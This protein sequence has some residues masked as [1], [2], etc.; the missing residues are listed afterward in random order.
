MNMGDRRPLASRD[1]R[2]AQATARRLAT[3]SVTPNQISQASMLAGALAGTAFWLGGESEGTTRLLL[4][5]GAALFCQLR[6]LCNL[7]D[8]MVAVEGGKASAEGPFWNE[9][10][11][12]IADIAIMV[13]IGYG[14]AMPHLGWA[15]AC[16]SVLTAYVR[17]LGRANGAPSDFSGP[18]AKP[19]R[20]AVATGAALLS[21][22][23]FL[24]NGR[25]EI[26]TLALVI[27]A[28]GAA[29]TALRRGWRQVRWLKAKRS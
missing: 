11:D 14:I 4:L 27:I 29:A 9:F 1:T 7:F 8:G 5:L 6:L 2:W 20:M 22:V 15:A 23:E 28:I 19:H 26:L 12:R 17:E 24:W 21:S 25:N 10:P 3:L 16:F 13:G 18:M